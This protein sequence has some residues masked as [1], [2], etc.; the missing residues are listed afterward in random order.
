MRS[1][2][3]QFTNIFP[4][5]ET[6]NKSSIKPNK[7]RPHSVAAQLTSSQKSEKNRARQSFILNTLCN[8]I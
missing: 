2:L 4:I 5:N 7:A 6:A 1:T 8:L 3:P